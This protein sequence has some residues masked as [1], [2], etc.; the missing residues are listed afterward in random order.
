MASFSEAVA[1]L[2]ASG[3][4]PLSASRSPGRIPTFTRWGGSHFSCK[5]VDS[6]IKAHPAFVSHVHISHHLYSP[7]SSPGPTCHRKRPRRVEAIRLKD[8]QTVIPAW[9]GWVFLLQL[10]LF[11]EHLGYRVPQVLSDLAQTFLSHHPGLFSSVVWF[12]FQC[13]I[14]HNRRLFGAVV[15]SQESRNSC[16]WTPGPIQGWMVALLQRQELGPH[17]VLVLL[18]GLSSVRASVTVSWG[19]PPASKEARDKPMQKWMP[20]AYTTSL[21]HILIQSSVVTGSC[22]TFI[23]SVVQ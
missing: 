10:L 8:S 19:C 6:G 11:C 13:E 20:T 15:M 23:L 1:A 5:T 3:A 4:T 16:V 18:P 9:M 2:V 22:S 21:N 12:G 7:E 17:R 14:S